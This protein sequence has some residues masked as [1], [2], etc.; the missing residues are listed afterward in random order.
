M[1]ATITEYINSHPEYN[2]WH[3]TMRRRYI[4]RLGSPWTLTVD[5][6]VDGETERHIMADTKQKVIKRLAGLLESEK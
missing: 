6:W 1:E 2:E 4:V 3:F 5:M